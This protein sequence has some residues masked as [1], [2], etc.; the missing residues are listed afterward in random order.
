MKKK[1][2][3]KAQRAKPP[4]LPHTL[5][6]DALIRDEEQNG[7][8]KKKKG[9]KPQPNYPGPFGRLPLPAGIIRKAYSYT[10]AHREG[11][12]LYLLVSKI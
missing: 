8:Q 10:L 7:R 5:A 9:A 3:I 1:K 12:G 2:G 4:T 11:V 6:I